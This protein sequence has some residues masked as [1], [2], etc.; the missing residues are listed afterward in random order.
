[1]NIP[2]PPASTRSP[3]IAVRP[4]QENELSAADHIIRLAF[5]VFL[6]LPEPTAF[7]GDA[8]DVRTRW[9]ANPATPS[10]SAPTLPPA[11]VA[12][13]PRPADHPPRLVG[14]GCGPAVDGTHPGLF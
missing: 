10:S 8:N 6:G 14:S 13:V 11:G 5:G 7:M 12:S 9:R 3:D 4:L 1:M 2:L